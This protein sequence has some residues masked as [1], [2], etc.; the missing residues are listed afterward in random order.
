[1]NDFSSLRSLRRSSIALLAAAGWLAL[2]AHAQLPAP[3]VSPAP[4]TNY[5]YD[6]EGNPTKTVVA[7][8]TAGMAFATTRSYDALNQVKTSVDAKSG[9]VQFSH[10]GQG[11]LTLVVDPRNLSTQYLLDGLGNQTAL[12]SPDT[13]TATALYDAAGNVTHRTDARGVT[14]DFVYDP[15]NRLTSATS[16]STGASARVFQWTYDQAGSPYGY[17]V[18]RLTTAASPE[19]STKFGYD[20]LGRVV[21][22]VQNVA[23]GAALTTGYGYDAAGHV[24]SITYPSGRVV[25]IAYAQGLPTTLSAAV[26]G[27]GG[28][29]LSN[30]QF[31]PFGDVRRWDWNM[32]SGLKAHE[33]VFDTSGRLVRYPLGPLVRD[34]VYDDA[35]RIK[36]FTHYDA[37][38]GAVQTAFNQSFLYD[39]LGRLIKETSATTSRTY[40]YD[41]SGNRTALAIGTSVQSYTTDPASNR[42]TTVSN[43]TRS[44]TYDASG[45]TKSDIATDRSTSYTGTYSLEGRL[46]AMAQGFTG[47]S[48]A[49][50]AQGQRVGRAY[51]DANSVPGTF[52][53]RPPS[54]VPTVKGSLL[55]S[56]AFYTYDLQGHLIGAYDSAGAALAE[57]VWLGDIPVAAFD[58]P[59]G[60]A[61][62][63]FI[64]A[65]HIDTPR[66][67][68]DPQGNVRWR[69]MADAFGTAAPETQPTASLPAITFN[70]RM[71]GQQYEP[72]GGRFYNYFRDFDPTIG[73]YVQSDPIGLGGGINTYAYVGENPVSYIDPDG[74]Q[75]IAACA[76]PAN[77]AA[78]A[79]AG[80]INATPAPNVGRLIVPLAR[81]ASNDSC[82]PG[83]PDGKDPCK[84][85]RKQLELHEQ[86]LKDFV[87]NPLAHD[88]RGRLSN[89]LLANDATQANRVYQGRLKEL[90][91]QIE[92]WKREIKKCE[93]R[94]GR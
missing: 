48:F 75:S 62:L 24:T 33:R 65:D 70:L 7:P 71:P 43:P 86:K 35:N 83:G 85:L 32:A 77:A 41:A 26:S 29:L 92:S 1:M 6:A 93:D 79:E 51:L 66:V 13:G 40:A 8:N 3:P 50:D 22:T 69:W 74:L 12:T 16:N 17:G 10:D 55:K 59:A 47:V 39:E 80:I 61:Q 67:L 36:T 58:S 19:A 5:E 30:I 87:N 27:S 52:Q 63:L 73:R 37:S 28:P 34:L 31:S 82:S 84:G 49:Y 45:N 15:L 68:T 14:T 4:V 54:W 42:L 81:A 78:C 11:R 57:Y 2:P 56:L 53:G 64:D 60:T 25:T 9:L 91:S 23:G 38:T 21:Q 90:R 76:N 94:N 44:F 20:A 72:F 88:N 46:V 18:G 89:A